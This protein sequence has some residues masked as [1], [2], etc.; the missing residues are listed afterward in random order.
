M[1]QFEKVERIAQK[2]GVSF[3]EAKN[4]LEENNWDMLDAMLALE[5]KGKSGGTGKFSTDYESQPGYKTVKI[6][7]QTYIKRKKTLGDKIKSLLKKSHVNHL[8]IR[9]GDHMTASLPLWAAILI[10]LR[11]WKLSIILILIGLFTGCKIALEGPDMEKA[12][13]VNKAMDKAGDALSKTAGEFK[14]SFEA[15]YAANKKNKGNKTAQKSDPSTVKCEPAPDTK[16]TETEAGNSSEGIWTTFGQKS[17][18]TFDTMSFGTAEKQT[19]APKAEAPKA[20]AEAAAETAAQPAQEADIIEK[21]VNGMDASQFQE[22]DFSEVYNLFN[23][24]SVTTEDGN[25]TLEL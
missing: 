12:E 6:N 3:E 10:F 24:N 5:K 19:E 13:S 17:E 4:V 23:G 1:D 15:G 16:T 2:A 7:D 20:E 9:R 18:T 8:V 21:T 14:S 22:K 11:F 25:I